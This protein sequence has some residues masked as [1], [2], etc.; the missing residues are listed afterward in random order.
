MSAL[1]FAPWRDTTTA[2]PSDDTEHAGKCNTQIIIYLESGIEWRRVE[3]WGNIGKGGRGVV[4][5][6][7]FRELVKANADYDSLKGWFGLA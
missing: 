5:D 7:D 4:W 2:T 3:T 6:L 1:C